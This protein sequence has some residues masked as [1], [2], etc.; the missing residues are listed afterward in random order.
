MDYFTNFLK[1]EPQGEIESGEIMI[2]TNWAQDA[3]IYEVS[4][5]RNEKVCF[6]ESERLLL[7]HDIERLPVDGCVDRLKYDTFT[8]HLFF[9]S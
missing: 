4:L 8:L 6:L 3:G 7:L 5:H 1:L 2:G 9:V